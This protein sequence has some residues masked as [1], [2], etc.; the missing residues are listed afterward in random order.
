MET[1]IKTSSGKT[2]RVNHWTDK[3]VRETHRSKGYD[4][5]SV[6]TNIEVLLPT[7]DIYRENYNSIFGH[8]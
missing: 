1:E 4:W 7:S 2:E 6:H 3:E 5:R 8:S